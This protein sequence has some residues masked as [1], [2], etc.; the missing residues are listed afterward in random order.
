MN[1]KNISI[2]T[3]KIGAIII[4]VNALNKF[5]LALGYYHTESG[6]SL[7]AFL[8]MSVLPLFLSLIISFLL[9]VSPKSILKNV[10]I[11]SET[12][13]SS[14][15]VDSLSMSR[16]LISIVGLYIFTNAIGDIVFYVSYI[17]ESKKQI[18]PFFVLPPQDYAGLIATICEFILGIAL[19]FV[20]KPISYYIEKFQ[21]ETKR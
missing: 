20:N 12:T 6:V 8:S 11:E 5:P 3:S 13:A 15:K 2:I 1:Y 9:W 19:I 17:S 4:L 7:A 18:G 10:L 14:A 21:N 16:I